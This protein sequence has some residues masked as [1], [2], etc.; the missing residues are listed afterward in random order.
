MEKIIIE[1][2]KNFE[3]ELNDAVISSKDEIVIVNTNKFEGIGEIIQA[4]VVLGG[5]TIP[6]IGKIII[7]AIRSKKHVVIKKK[8]F[9]VS[10]ISEKNA[11]QIL[12]DLSHG[13]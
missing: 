7:E 6:I 8:G 4:M 9:I 1:V 3:K 12:K 2:D 11:V 13:D 10:G 5:V